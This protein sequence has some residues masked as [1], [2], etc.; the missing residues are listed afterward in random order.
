M[1]NSASLDAV[2]HLRVPGGGLRVDAFHVNF[3]AALQRQGHFHFQRR[4]SSAARSI[5]AGPVSPAWRKSALPTIVSAALHVDIGIV[6][7]A[8]AELVAQQAAHGLVDACLGDLPA[9]HQA[10]ITSGQASPPN[11]STPASRAF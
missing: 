3:A 9:A 10:T 11:W 5:C 6:E 2:D 7:Q 8:Q 1:A 4:R